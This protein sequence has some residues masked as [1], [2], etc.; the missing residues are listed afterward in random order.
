MLIVQKFGGATVGSTEKLAKV[1]ARIKDKNPQDQLVIVVSAMG[2]TTDRLLAMARELSPE[3]S[4]PEMDILL[5]TG[6]M[7]SMSLLTMAL[8][9]QG[10]P[11]AGL[12]GYQAGIRTDPFF[13]NAS[14]SE[15]DTTAIRTI[16]KQKKVA[17]IAGF[18]GHTADGQLTTLGRGGSDTTALGISAALGADRCEILKDVPAVFSAD[19]RVVPT[20]YP[21][22]QLSYDA[23]LEMTYWGAKVLQYR[24]VEIAK[25][26]KIPLYVGPANSNELGTTIKETLMIE[27]SEVLALNS[28]ETVLQIETLHNALGEALN[29]LKTELNSHK[30][31]FPQILH[32]ESVDGKM[33]LFVTGPKEV[34]SDLSKLTSINSAQ[35][36]HEY[37]SVT[38]TCRGSTKPEIMETIVG[39]L[40][41]QGIRVVN[42]IVSSMSITVFIEKSLRVKAIQLLH[43]LIPVPVL[44]PYANR[45]FACK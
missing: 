14:I 16:L 24:S 37:A 4:L 30:I 40:E 1:A 17:V 44:R 26:F 20:A 29:W 22:Q 36:F 11:S 39:T 35:H 12:C 7:V 18:Q 5:S 42:L 8:N 9:A 38:A 31:P 10:C 19:P 25:H 15:I 2:D 34:V 6:E 3:P 43:E 21:L 28:H 41:S 45:Y 23:L 13:S 27:D 32:S 33:D